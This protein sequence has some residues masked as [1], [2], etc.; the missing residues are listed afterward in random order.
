MEER[1]PS[2]DDSGG[3][4]VPPLS[5]RG[6]VGARLCGAGRAPCS[7]PIVSRELKEGIHL[8]EKVAD[9]SGELDS[10]ARRAVVAEAR[11]G[12]SRPGVLAGAEA[13]VP[14]RPGLY[15]IHGDRQTWNELG[16]GDPPD[17]RPLYIGKAEDSLVTRDLKTHFGDGR[18]GRSTVRR[19]FAALLHET[20]S[21]RGI[22]RNIN[23]PGYFSSFGL[24]AADDAALTRWLGR[25]LLLATWQKPA[26][27]AFALE[28]IEG[29]LLGELAPPLNLKGAATPW[30]TQVKEARALMADEAR[31]WKRQSAVAEGSP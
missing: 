17:A 31:D 12:L 24:S 14:N 22:P 16:L 26:D 6:R 11:D 21:L 13:R 1:W 8:T 25:R 9:L 7:G 10:Q 3:V 29:E 4:G 20:L 30:T 28:E 27:C 5:R 15:A 23:K 19:S 2:G 18:T